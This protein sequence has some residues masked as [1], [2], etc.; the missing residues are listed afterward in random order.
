MDIAPISRMAVPDIAYVRI[1]E[2]ILSGRVP[3]GE[4]L[5]AER[6]LALAF[7]VNRHAIR[8]ALKRVQQAG[9]IRIAHGGKT[10]VLNWREN[11]R[12]ETLSD[13]VAAGVV[14]P[15]EIMRDIA[16][17]R[18]SIGSDAARLCAANAT[19]EQLERIESIARDFPEDG[20]VEKYGEADL[21]FWVA[22][23]DG[24]G[25]LAYRLALNSLVATFDELGLPIVAEWI[26]G[27]YADR[28]GRIAL[29][30]LI[31]ARDGEGAHRHAE[32]LLSH[33]VARLDHAAPE[34]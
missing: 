5:P 29:A 19:T 1:V 31:A 32:R 3:A 33:F 23:I 10:R 7:Q 25:N 17:M 30:E 16:V 6:E 27:E 11:A 28:A 12:L 24:C 14:P 8:E 20:P 4:A 2:E 22:V 21:A 13:I 26:G 9:L 34:A 18:R 15:L